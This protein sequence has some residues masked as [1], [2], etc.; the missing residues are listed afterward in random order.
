MPQIET[1][2]VSPQFSEELLELMRDEL[3]PKMGTSDSQMVRHI[4]VAWLSEHGYLD[5]EWGAEDE[6]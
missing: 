4:T 2:R 1:S 5:A 6:I 3:Q